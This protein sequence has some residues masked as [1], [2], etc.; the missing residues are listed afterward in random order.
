M[1]K[2]F[3]IVM[4]S[5][6]LAC[7]F[8]VASCQRKIYTLTFEENGGTEV[9]DL[10]IPVNEI[11]EM[12]ENPTKEGYTFGGWYLDEGLKFKYNAGKMEGNVTI[13]AKWNVNSYSINY[14]T[15]GAAQI[16]ADRFDFGSEIQLPETPTKT[17]YEFIGWYTDAELEE[18]FTLTTMPAKDITLYAAWDANDFTIKFVSQDE[19]VEALRQV[20]EYGQKVTQPE[21]PVREGYT[22]KGWYL[23][24]E[25]YDFST[26]ITEEVTLTAKWEINSYKVT[27]DTVGGSEI[28]EETY[29]YHAN[30]VEPTRPTKL[31]YVFGGWTLNDEP[32]DFAGSQMPANDITIKVNWLA[33]EYAIYFNKNNAQATGTVATIAT[34]YE[35]EEEIPANAFELLGYTFVEWNTRN[36]GLGTSYAPGTKV[37]QLTTTNSFTLYAIWSANSYTVK[38]NAN[39]GNGIMANQE[40]VYDTTALNS[41]EFTKVGYSFVEWN[42]APDG[43]GTSYAANA[44]NITSV[45]GEEVE[46]FAIWSANSYTLS[47][48][49]N[50]GEGN[51]VDQTVVYD[52]T[53]IAANTFTRTGY[54]FAGWNTKADGTGTNVEVGSVFA[55]QETS[56]FAQWT[57][58]S[59]NLTIYYNGES[60]SEKITV[61]YGSLINETEKALQVEA[62]PNFD[63][64]FTY[65]GNEEFTFGS[66]NMPAND[67]AIYATY[68][69]Q[70]SITFNTYGGTSVAPING[71]VG[72]AI[73]APT[74]T[75]VKEGYT[76]DGWFTTSECDVEFDFENTVMPEGGLTIHAGWTAHQYYVSFNANSGEGEMNNQKMTYDVSTLNSNAFTKYGYTFAGWNTAADGSGKSYSNNSSENITSEA[77]VTVTLYAQWEANVINI[78]YKANGGQGSDVAQNGAIFDS[79]TLLNNSFTRVGYEFVGW[80]TDD[81]GNGTVYLPGSKLTTT[82]TTLYAK[83]NELSYTITLQHGMKDASVT[84]DPIKYTGSVTLSLPSTFTYEGYTFMGWALDEGEEVKFNANDSY[85]LTSLNLN[86]NTKT[87][88][89]VGVWKANTLNIKFVDTSTNEEI[90]TLNPK[91][92]DTYVSLQIPNDVNTK[93]GHRFMGYYSDSACTQKLDFTSASTKFDNSFDTVYV[94]LEPVKY[95]V[96]FIIDGEAVYTVTDKYYGDTVSFNDYIAK[97]NTDLPVI[98]K[99][100]GLLL[101]VIGGA[102]PTQLPNILQGQA[103]TVGAVSY[104]AGEIAQVYAVDPRI[105]S[106]NLSDIPGLYSIVNTIKNDIELR[107]ASF[108]KDAE[109]NYVPLRE[110][111]IF[112]NWAIGED[113]YYSASE[114]EGSKYKG[115][116]PASIHT[117]DGTVINIVAKWKGV[118]GITGIKY[119]SETKVLSWNEVE[120]DESITEYTVSYEIYH[121]YLNNGN[122]VKVLL[123]TYKDA[124]VVDGVVKYQVNYNST[125]TNAYIAPGNYEV[126][127]IAKVLYTDANGDQITLTSEESKTTFKMPVAL[128]QIVEG[129]IGA[130]GDYYTQV[131]PEGKDYSVFYFYTDMEYEFRGSSFIFVDEKNENIVNA[132]VYNNIVALDGGFITTNSSI[133]TFYFRTESKE[134]V[135]YQGIVLPFTSQFDLGESLQ[136]FK[137]YNAGTMQGLYLEDLTSKVYQ[138]GVNTPTKGNVTRVYKDPNTDTVIKDNGFSFD[139]SIN[140]TGGKSID[141]T[142]YPDYLVFKFTDVTNGV[143]IPNNIMGEYVS[144]NNTWYFNENLLTKRYDGTQLVDDANAANN[145]YSVEISIRSEYVPNKVEGKV[146]TSK[147]FMFQLNNAINVF[148][149]EELRNVFEDTTLSNGINIHANITADLSEAQLYGGSNTR[150]DGY[151]SDSHS[152]GLAGHASNLSNAKGSSINVEADYVMAQVAL[153]NNTGKGLNTGH[154]YLRASTQ[155]LN[156]NYVINGNL[157]NVDGSD[158]EYSSIYSIGNLSSVSGYKIANTKTAIFTYYVTGNYGEK[159]FQTSNSQLTV[160]DLSIIGNTK[161]SSLSSDGIEL[162]NRNSGGHSG[163]SVAFGG[164]A[165]INNTTITNATIAVYLAHNAKAD[166]DYLYSGSNWANTVY[167]F[168]AER[169]E[170]TNSHIKDSGGAALHI[171][172][173]KSTTTTKT[174]ASIYIDDTNTIENYVSGEEGYFKANSMEIIVLTLKSGFQDIMNGVTGNAYSL[175][176]RIKNPVTNAESEKLNFI[177]L[178]PPAGQNKSQVSF[179]NCGSLTGQTGLGRSEISLE[180]GN[181]T[182][183]ENKAISTSPLGLSVYRQLPAMN[184]STMQQQTSA[185][186]QAIGATDLYGL[187]LVANGDEMADALPKNIYYVSSY[188]GGGALGVI[189]VVL[190]ATAN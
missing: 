52:T 44:T 166:M 182:S 51:S 49:A 71:Y 176:T 74:V 132:S 23:E 41:N 165:N 35:K 83:W 87:T 18:E 186:G 42:T 110:N 11:P 37:S 111:L 32:F 92:D 127:I 172:D 85:A 125:G 101:L 120:V 58:N 189:T 48:F 169:V 17:G 144:A 175:L 190:G 158:L 163:I 67:F 116:I 128:S 121:E 6:L 34:N 98:Q 108:T 50:G 114:A 145:I 25:A 157:F 61:A 103:G 31:G 38:F 131:K 155:D 72:D 5:I 178:S 124:T 137:S 104:A 122:V 141:F 99:F 174:T 78:T 2:G 109:G 177:L 77:D 89:L 81:A 56:L 113:A 102:D 161:N 8:F 69:D 173:L 94:K 115:T 29:T 95:T 4:Y 82:A 12:P 106:A 168:G 179:T 135:Y 19:E 112:G 117:E 76:F 7:M 93:I 185:I 133:G 13:Y 159:L 184:N 53:K 130:E 139:L 64:W 151:V 91:Y 88:S 90:I 100:E 105:A 63:K 45:P 39:G 107:V 33:G 154:V 181:T 183:I 10:Q 129:E 9:S 36:D 162:M 68:K 119:D 147:S 55:M 171:E 60:D 70:V 43:T 57:V 22:F 1:K 66:I 54:T 153:N 164:T 170:L 79:S 80:T 150:F 46:L 3:K 152:N 167:G 21:N 148:T 188:N 140:T 16:T 59:Y 84:L 62:Q 123:D 187:F 96:K 73:V 40:L 149:H 136:Q 65:P 180:I 26:I 142:N 27:Y 20:V 24:E 28:A 146:I 156:E 118:P 15:N 47:Y 160:N 14:V 126:K 143:E 97:L 138:I 30:L 134:D 86:H 75:M